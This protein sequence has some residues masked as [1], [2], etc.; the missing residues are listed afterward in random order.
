MSAYE[1]RELVKALLGK[2]FQPDKV[3]HA[4]G[5]HIFYRLWVAG[6]KTGVKTFVSKAEREFPEGLLRRRASQIGL[7]KP[8]FCDF[9]QC[10]LSANGYV[11]I[12]FQ[13]G[14]LHS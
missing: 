9:I 10:P 8:E 6:R 5:R 13:K 4:G 1:T 14:V 3:G 7:T 11:T 12:L 2:G